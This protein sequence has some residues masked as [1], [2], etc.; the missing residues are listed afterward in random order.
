[1]LYAFLFVAYVG[2]PEAD[3]AFGAG[4]LRVRGAPLT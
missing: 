4:L 1:M 2:S 3:T